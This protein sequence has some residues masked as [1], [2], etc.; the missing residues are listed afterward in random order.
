VKLLE[1]PICPFGNVWPMDERE[2]V[3]LLARRVQ[4]ARGKGQARPFFLC[5]LLEQ[6]CQQRQAF[7]ASIFR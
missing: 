1:Q 7:L 5:I 6:G 3:A 2:E 4:H